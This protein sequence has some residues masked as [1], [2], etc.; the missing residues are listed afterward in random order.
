VG[1]AVVKDG[2]LDLAQTGI[3]AAPAND[4][5][6]VG[7][8]Q[9]P[10]GPL[11]RATV[12][13][14]HDVLVLLFH[15]RQPPGQIV[16]SCIERTQLGGSPAEPCVQRATRQNDRRPQPRQ[17]VTEAPGE[18]LQPGRGAPGS[19]DGD[20]ANRGLPVAADE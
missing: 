3:R 4:E 10:A 6:P 17:A 8:A 14:T 5:H 9:A 13:T 12:G 15:R 1:L 7:L 20:D 18:S 11:G 19:N 2:R 16:A